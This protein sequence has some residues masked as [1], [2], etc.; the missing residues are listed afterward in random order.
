[1]LCCIQYA[2]K[3]RKISS[4][5]RTGDQFSFW[6][7]RRAMTKNVQTTAQLH[8]FHMLAKLC[9][10]FFKLSYSSTWTKNLQMYKLGF[11][12]HMNKSSNCQHS[13]DHGKSKGIPVKHLFLLHWLCETFD[14]VSHHKLWKILNKIKHQITLPVS[15]EICM[16]V[17]KEQ[18]E[19][20][21]NN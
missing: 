8:S 16:W 7:Q 6:S 20:E 19:P 11:E 21:W 14:Y 1:M 10:K 17:K 9:L 2:N 12:R 13:L 5:R 4:G 18:L 15:W 3:F